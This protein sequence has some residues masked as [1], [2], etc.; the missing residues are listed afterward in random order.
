MTTHAGAVA[1]ATAA[2]RADA[3]S[4]ADPVSLHAG[5]GVGSGP[6]WVLAVVALATVAT[7]ALLGLTFAAYVRRKSRSYL[8]VV[9][10]VAALLARSVVAGVTFA[11]MVSP[12]GH[13]LL[14]HGLDV[15]LVGLVVAA[16]YYARS[17]EREGTAT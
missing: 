12:A 3:L 14:E 2:P 5:V 15:V 7:A 9:A 8:L 13:H 17:V 6:P 11:G 1:H 10:A 4:L 16:V